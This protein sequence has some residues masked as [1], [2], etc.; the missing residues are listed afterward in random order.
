MS[1]SDDV[2]IEATLVAQDELDSGFESKT[3]QPSIRSNER[4]LQSKLVVLG[5]LF[6]ATGALGI[7]LL[8]INRK[9]S[10]AERIAWAII[11]TLYT[12]ALIS[13]VAGMWYVLIQQIMNG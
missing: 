7:P 5:I 9:F 13:L 2:P 6:L 4:L 10:Q 12:V 8:W 11:V 3:A 1:S